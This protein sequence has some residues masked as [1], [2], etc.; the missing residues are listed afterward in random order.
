MERICCS[1]VSVLSLIS[2]HTGSTLDWLLI[3]YLAYVVEKIEVIAR[4]QRPSSRGDDDLRPSACDIPL[5]PQFKIVE[6]RA[7][8][9]GV[10]LRD[11]SRHVDF[12]DLLAF[13]HHAD[14]SIKEK[15]LGIP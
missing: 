4:F 6:V 11:S 7:C 13:D 2:V 10:W 9:P 14:D 8:D 15:V 1:S 3:D 12:Q 5:M